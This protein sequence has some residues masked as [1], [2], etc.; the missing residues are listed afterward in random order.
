[1]T[2]EEIITLIRRRSETPHVD[3]KA[4]FE[5]KKENRD[6]QLGLIRDMI[7]MA[8]VQDGG[9]ISCNPHS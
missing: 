2:L 4:G 8:N 9:A 1:M 7:A 3:Y 6:H 5:W